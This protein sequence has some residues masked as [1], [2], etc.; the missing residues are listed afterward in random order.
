MAFKKY[1]EKVV[2]SFE[3]N[4][5][6]D[7]LNVTDLT[8]DDGDHRIDI[9]QM[10]TGTDGELHFTQKGVRFSDEI[11]LDVMKSLVCT[12][13]EDDKTALKQFIEDQDEYIGTDE[14]DDSE[15]D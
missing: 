2:G 5:R 15:D 13:N 7:A 11:L 10:Y 6:G 4:A 14:P 9:R 1:N 3:L 8:A 12:M